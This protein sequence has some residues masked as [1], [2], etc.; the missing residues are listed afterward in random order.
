M[1]GVRGEHLQTNK[2]NYS[3]C[4]TNTDYI[5]VIYTRL[6]HQT[7]KKNR[8]TLATKK[9]LEA[10]ELTKMV[11]K[12]ESV[13]TYRESVEDDQFSATSERRQ[14]TCLETQGDNYTGK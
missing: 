8:D 12:E 11:T 10:C 5:N 4:D 3:A 14:H 9:P 7:R 2:A 6:S 1:F 13:K